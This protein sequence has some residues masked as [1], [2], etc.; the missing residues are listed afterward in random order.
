MLPNNLHKLIQ[1]SEQQTQEPEQSG[2]TFR[3]GVYYISDI[4][5]IGLW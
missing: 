5:Y 3:R 2:K 1:S 4:A